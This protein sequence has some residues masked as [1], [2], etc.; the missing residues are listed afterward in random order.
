M[1]RLAI[2]RVPWSNSVAGSMAASAPPRAPAADHMHLRREKMD[3]R[4]ITKFPCVIDL[5]EGRP[6]PMPPARCGQVVGQRLTMKVAR[7]IVAGRTR[8][9]AIQKDP[10]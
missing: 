2:H 9:L 10:K 5:P 8:G 4:R 3:V 1:R 7:R 6:A